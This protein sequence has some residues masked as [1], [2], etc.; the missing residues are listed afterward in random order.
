MKLALRTQQIIAE[1]TGVTGSI[2]PLGGSYLV[3][4]FTDRIEGEVNAYLEKIDGLGGTLACIER[5]FF[6]QEIADAAYAYQLAKERGERVV[7]GVNKYR[8]EQLDIPFALHTVDADVERRQ[9]ERLARVKAARD[10][11][12]AEKRLKELQEAARDEGA[13]LMPVTVEAVKAHATGGEIV[14]ALVEAWGRYSESPV[15]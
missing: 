3:E 15:F 9:I 11:A 2:D 13:N 4:A 12:L 10:T 14:K 5:N 8:E 1:E 7:V 6:Q